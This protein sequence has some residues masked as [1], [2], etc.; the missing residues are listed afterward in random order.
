MEPPSLD[1]PDFYINRELGKLAF[2]RRVFEQ[3]CDL[4]TPLLER[5]E[6][7]CISCSNL[8]EFFEVR[9]AGLIHQIRY[10]AARNT[11]DGLSPTETLARIGVEAHALVAD[12]YRLLNEDILPALEREGIRFVRRME[13]SE[14]QTAWIKKYFD[15]RILPIVSPIRLDPAHPFPSILNKSLNFIVSL[16]GEDAFG[17]AGEMAV[18]QAPR[19]L[20]RL[21][22][23]S[24]ATHHGEEGSKR[25]DFAFLSSVIHAH[26][27]DLFPGMEIIGCYQ[28]R[29][30]RNSDLFVDTEEVDDLMRALVGE[31][32]SRR[33][34]EE[35]RL[36]VAD[37]CPDD[38]VE[39]LMR[40]FGLAKEMVFRVNGP[41]NLHRLRALPNLVERRDLKYPPFTP[42]LPARIGQGRNTR[43]FDIIAAGDILLHHPFQSFAPVIDLVRQAAAD[44]DVLAI[45]QTL[46]R[47]GAKS[48]LVDALVAAARAGKE[49]TICIEL[50]ARFDEEANISL[51]EKLK[52]AGAHVVYGVV[53]YKTHAKMLLIVR[54]EGDRMRRYVHLGTGNY[55]A[56]TARSYTD[57]GLLT[58]DPEIGK[59][60]HEIFMQLTGLGQASHLTRLLQSPFTLHDG[61]LEFIRREADIARSGVP[62]RIIAKMNALTEPRIIRALYRASQA[63]A[64][65]SLIVRGVCGLRPGIPGISDNIEVRSVVGRFLEHSRVFFFE[66]DGDHRL[67]AASADWMNRNLIQRVETCFPILD[68]S[69]RRQVFDDELAI[70]L[71]DNI[72]SWILE[73]DG[74]WKR[75]S[76]APGEPIVSAQQEILKRLGI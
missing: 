60:V 74:S 70:Y 9:V 5:L 28:F 39:F 16:K 65:I 36:E 3:A 18:V 15:D 19:L 54:R 46:Y 20:P 10:G 34:G 73:A 7:L 6:F 12:Q 27:S 11:P 40:Q 17:Q 64:R 24:D 31:L 69:L 67:F 71:K 50:R 53:G 22:K 68:E 30:T 61:L 21:I 66:N 75:Q 33:Y 72:Q 14:A 26:V 8:D 23:L 48:A 55:H 38:L 59:D 47:V 25:H 4:N 43:L 35:V 45:K 52:E 41:V 42:G 51:A 1:N 44:P 76:P 32:P 13:W 49:V 62:G 57:I 29:V 58:A 63:G 56:V 2:D 37:N